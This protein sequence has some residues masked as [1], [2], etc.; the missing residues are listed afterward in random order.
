M[1]GNQRNQRCFPR[2]PLV[3]PVNVRGWLVAMLLLSS[4][5]AAQD[6]NTRFLEGLRQRR[7]YSL[8]ESYC[9]E[10]LENTELS[11]NPAGRSHD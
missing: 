3:L 2:V 9:R 1:S 8:A 6:D 11:E 5:V 4:P 10:Q 7:L